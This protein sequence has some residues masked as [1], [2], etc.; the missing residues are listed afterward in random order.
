MRW[1]RLGALALAAL[2]VAGAAQ[3]VTPRGYDR[4][5]R[6]RNHEPPLPFPEVLHPQPAPSLPS[7]FVMVVKAGAADPEPGGPVN[8]PREVAERLAACFHPP[9]NA[10][11]AAEITLR[12]QFNRDGG[13]VGE[14]LVTYVKVGDD[15]DARAAIVAAL[16]S[17]LKRCTPLRFTPSLGAAIAGYPFAIRFIASGN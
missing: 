11:P 2:C 1:A 13:V 10:G 14:P 16:L 15:A 4:A 8:R 3:A 9:G 17:D 7:G 5:L 6:K 12:V